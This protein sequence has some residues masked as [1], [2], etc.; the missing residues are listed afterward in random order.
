MN[1]PHL[2]A[3]AVDGTPFPDLSTAA[4]DEPELATLREVGRCWGRATGAPAQWRE[5][6]PPELR[7]SDR[8]LDL[9]R[10]ARGRL[11][12]VASPADPEPAGRSPARLRRLVLGPPLASSAIAQ[13]RMRKLVALPVLSADV[14]SSVAYAPE[15]MLAVLVTAGAAGTALSIPIAAAVTALMIAVGLSYRQ[16]IKAYPHGGGSYIVAGD[17]LGRHAGLIAAAGLMTDYALTVAV[18]VAAGISA[19]TSAVP[20]VA[21]ATVPIG[22]GVIALLLAGNLRGVRQAGALF[23]APTYAFLAMMAALVVSGLVQAAAHGFVRPSPPSLHATSGLGLLLV[24]RAFSSGATAMTGIEAV[25]NAVPVFRQEAWRNARATL[26]TMIVLL[27]VL[28]VGTMALIELD[29]VLPAAGQTVLSQ[30]GRRAFGTGAAYALLQA[31]TA[32]ILLLAANTAFNDFPRLLYLMA[33]DS[34][35][36]RL[37]LRLGDRL[38]FTNGL[39]GLSAAAAGIFVAFAGRTAALIPLY[40]VGVFLAF[41]LSQSGMVVRWWRRREAGWRTSIAVN[42]AGAVLSALVLVIAAV[43]KFTH[44]AWV[45]VVVTALIVIVAHRVHG[46][47]ETVRRAIALRPPPDL[48]Q[49]TPTSGVA[50]EAEE[51]PEQI[52]HVALVP[53]ASLNLASVRALA[54]AVSM[55][56]PVLAVHIAP[57]ETEAER[58]RAYWRAWGD[59]V[60]LEIVVSPYRAVV[61][62]LVA[63]VTQLH[64]RRP[65]LT[66][67]V[68]LP[69]LVVPRWWHRP[70]HNHVAGRLAHALRPLPK[71]VVTTVPFHLPS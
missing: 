6:L 31:S 13:E 12:P 50:G 49:G 10:R 34:Y 28:F 70:L 48:V 5:A 56:H 22:L 32:A 44:G 41:T 35:A 67:T 23:A 64:A 18:S 39:I 38:A 51:S 62:P 7:P 57:S 14:L 17:N 21:P 19:I 33:R 71:T 2:A 26:T 15:A 4:L 43:A 3:P 65:D 47:Y 9:T 40:A 30:L 20:S 68:I 52:R 55:R 69:E 53:V 66:M 61:A 46:H 27:V 24:L 54:Y 11:V 8:A 1:D 42:A 37:F 63:K 25:S 16:T 29:G 58:F 36:P 60:P 45:A 59:H